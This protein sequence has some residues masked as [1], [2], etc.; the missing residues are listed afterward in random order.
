M[1]QFWRGFLAG[2]LVYSLVPLLAIGILVIVW[3]FLF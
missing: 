2:L 1:K 3:S